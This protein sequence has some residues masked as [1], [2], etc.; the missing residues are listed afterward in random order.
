LPTRGR[1]TWE[2]EEERSL[3]RSASDSRGPKPRGDSERT[4][5]GDDVSGDALAQIELRLRV[6]VCVCV[7]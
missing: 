2:P 6:C 1:R 3:N 4:D 5:V 7:N